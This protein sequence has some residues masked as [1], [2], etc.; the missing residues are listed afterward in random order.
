MINNSSKLINIPN[1]LSILRIIFTFVILWLLN[2]FFYGW[3]FALFLLTSST[4]LL[5]GYLARKFNQETSVG[6]CLDSLADSIFNILLVVYFYNHRDV[7][8]YYLILLLLR[9]GLQFIHSLIK[10]GHA[11][12]WMSSQTKRFKRWEPRMVFFVLFFLFLK[13]IMGKVNG[14]VYNGID[15]IILPYVLMPLSALTN[16]IG[17]IRFLVSRF[18]ENK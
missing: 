8:S 6:A 17:S 13:V 14:P 2:E 16:L 9:N 11:P 1:T 15:Q 10:F 18:S 4:D 5:D 3:A 12:K 7:P